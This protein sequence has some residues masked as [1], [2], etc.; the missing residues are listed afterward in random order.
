LRRYLA[1]DGK[2]GAYPDYYPIMQAAKYIGCPP[3]EL[4]EQS[5][6]WQDK[7]LICMTAENEAQEIISKRGGS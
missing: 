7:A 2:M 6:W 4:L 3:W 5:A 1:T